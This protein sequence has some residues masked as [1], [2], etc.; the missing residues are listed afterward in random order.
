[1]LTVPERAGALSCLIVFRI[2]RNGEK[3]DGKDS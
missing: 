2:F 3:P 1:M